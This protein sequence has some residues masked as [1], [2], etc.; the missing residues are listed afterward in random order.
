[1]N[2]EPIIKSR[3][4][5]F[6]D[7]FELSS[8]GDGV[9]FEKFVNHAILS[10]HQPD[11]FGS[12]SELLDTICVGG[13]NDMG[14][15]GIAIKLNGLLIKDIQEAS[16]VIERFQRITVEFIFIQS[17]M[18]AEFDSGEFLKF[19]AGVRDFISENHTQPKNNL[20]ENALNIKDY[21]LSD[22]IVVMWDSNPAI[23][24]YYVAM[25]KW[26]NSEHLTAHADQFTSDAGENTT[27][28]EC[29]V[30]FVDADGLKTI[31]DNNENKFQATIEAI[32]TMPL[33]EVDGV[34]N[35]C[36][37]LCYAS[38]LINIL[39][40]DEGVIRKSLFDDNVRDYQGINNVND[41]ISQTIEK[42][43]NIFGLLN[44]GITIVCDEY[45]PSNR[46]IT[47]M[48]PQIVNGCQTS[49]VLFYAN[50][51]GRE[52]KN[53]PLQIKI[54]STNDLNI[55]NQIVRGT[56][57]QNIVYD[58][59]F[60]TTKRFH[61]ELEEFFDAIGSDYKKIYYERRSKQFSHD[62]RIKQTDKVNLKTITQYII[63][64]F[65]N[66]P[67]MSHRHEAKLLPEFGNRIFLDHQSKLPYYAVSLLFIKADKIFR[68]EE[69]KDK[70]LQAY[71][72]HIL[73]VFRELLLGS[74]PS[75]NNEKK[76]DKYCEKLLNCIIDH[77]CLKENLMKAVNVFQESTT[78]WTKDLNRNIDGRKDILEF[79]KIL[80]NKCAEGS[81]KNDEPENLEEY[82]Y[83]L[84]V[85]IIYD[86]NGDKCGFIR[87]KNGDVFF[88]SKTNT[89]LDFE[90]IKGVSVAYK[91]EKN[92]KT[93]KPIAIDVKRIDKH[94]E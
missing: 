14:I 13:S 22:D 70:K 16:D 28:D 51:K 41:E 92:I 63:A 49:H 75:L 45:T 31:C 34:T 93:G 73:M 12:D 77:D 9:A 74:V 6:R 86:R 47:L 27:Y 26:R 55:T 69:L 24:L 15:D 42:D 4:Q 32:D 61:K 40:T 1:M 94:N 35:S 72:P 43:P 3:F 76:V 80:L 18:R 59:A 79:T 91:L 36:I 83:G 64:L 53:V 25:G 87:K 44:N 57:R 88:H 8:I 37:A 38:E 11:A 17:K 81:H 10:G 52:I 21:L 48:N 67:H 85:K 23:R 2:V 5:R 46:R 50:Q 39:S 29:N 7:N 82:N 19:T 71:R 90:D 60:E 58:E 78:Y 89:Q 66:Q 30:H 65:L 84:V 20:I 54:I 68:S 56:N 62:P 33:T